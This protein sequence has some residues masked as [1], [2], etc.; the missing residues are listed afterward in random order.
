M[1]LL[2]RFGSDVLRLRMSTPGGRASGYGVSAYVTRGVLI[3]TG[4]PALAGP[5]TAW[6][7]E[8]RPRG[9]LLTHAHEDHAGNVDRMVALGLPLGASAATVAMVAR[10]GPIGRYRQVVWGQ[11]RAFPEVARTPRFDDPALQLIHTPGHSGDHHVVWDEERATVFAGD[12][13]LG[14]RVREARPDEDPRELAASLRRVLA[15]APQTLYCAHRGL[16]AEPIPSLVRKAEWLAEMMGRMESLIRAGWSDRAVSR[17]VLGREG[18]AFYVSGGDLSRVNF[19]RAV[20]R[21]VE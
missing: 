11:P 10:P 2:E 18:P 17:E 3:D 13:F 7:R 21:G 12:L 5:M 8:A 15:L 19:V 14:I 20:R 16:V 1:F 6:A 9:V 4:C